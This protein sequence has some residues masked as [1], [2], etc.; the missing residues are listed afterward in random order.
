MKDSRFFIILILILI[1]LTAEFLTGGYLYYKT[2]KNHFVT[3]AENQL[4][5]IANLKKEEISNWR[6]ECLRGAEIFYKNPAF[7][8]VVRQ[9]FE[10]PDDLALRN[11]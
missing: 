7:S 1:F 11:E 8:V 9:F 4:K 10:K 5:S 6:S 2:Q 3:E